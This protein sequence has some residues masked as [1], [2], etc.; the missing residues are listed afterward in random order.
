MKVPAAPIAFLLSA[1]RLHRNNPWTKEIRSEKELEQTLRDYIEGIANDCHVNQITPA[2][3]HW[4]RDLLAWHKL[5]DSGKKRF[6][7]L[8]SQDTLSAR[9]LL[10]RFADKHS[11]QLI[12]DTIEKFGPPKHETRFWPERHGDPP[13][14][15]PVSLKPQEQWTSLQLLAHTT[16]ASDRPD[17]LG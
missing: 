11:V 4:L 5:K 14:P 10:V 7:S 2:N 8:A 3:E 16:F 1:A 15:S 13:V 9:A 6:G 17:L 12:D